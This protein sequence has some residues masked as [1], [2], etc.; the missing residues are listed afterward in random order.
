MSCQP[1]LSRPPCMQWSSVLL[2]DES[3]WKDIGVS[4]RLAAASLNGGCRGVSIWYSGI[5]YD[6]PRNLEQKQNFGSSSKYLYW[7][8][9]GFQNN[10]WNG[11]T[12]QSVA[13]G[14]ATDG[15]WRTYLT[16][17]HTPPVAI[18]CKYYQSGE[19]YLPHLVP[20]ILGLISL[21]VIQKIVWCKFLPPQRL[22]G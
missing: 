14:Y 10:K 11:K 22:A 8:Y 17:V 6:L 4:R 20:C 5:E 2:E 19:E 9:R 16:C 12:I 18:V 3:R 15:L 13:P 1:P 7:I 21:W